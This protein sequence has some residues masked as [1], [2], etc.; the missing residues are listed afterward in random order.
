MGQGSKEISD[1]VTV[2]VF[3]D[4]YAAR[5]FQIPLNWISRFGIF[6]GLLFGLTV[7]SVFFA[8][9]YYRVAVKTDLS[10]V[11]DLEQELTDMRAN[12]KSVDAK[13]SDPSHTL[14]TPP[15]PAHIAEAKAKASV[16]EPIP[17]GNGLLF[18]AFPASVS[19][20]IPDPSTL[21]FSVKNPRAQ[22]RGKNLRVQFAL[23]YTKED[24]GTQTGRILVLARGREA[25]LAYPEGVFNHVGAS[26]LIAPENG[27]SFSVS[28]YREVKADFGPVRNQQA[29]DEV[30]IFIFSKENQILAHQKFSP[31]SN[32]I[33]HPPAPT[34]AETTTP[35][36]APSPETPQP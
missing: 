28:R 25:L 35:A 21:S 27:E 18:A 29:L 31:H 36:V 30:E 19:S 10:R 9:K 13:A 17:V 26:E 14:I 8:I 3:K 11:Q 23:E 32:R 24:K 4:N 20:D 34:A 2:L 5:T 16:P 33:E 12:L 6:L 1:K 7:T 15:A 22:W